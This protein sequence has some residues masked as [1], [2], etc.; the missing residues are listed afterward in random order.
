MTQAQQ[1]QQQAD[2][3]QD[4]PITLNLTLRKVNYILQV[5]SQL[6]YEKA[7][8]PISDIQNMVIEQVRAAQA[9]QEAMD[10]AKSPT[11]STESV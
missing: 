5:M 11:E 8:Q 7:F 1:Q 10:A 6:P 3:M 9:A 2:K 4:M